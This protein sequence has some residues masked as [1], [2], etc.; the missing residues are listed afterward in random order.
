[1]IFGLGMIGRGNVFSLT[2]LMIDEEIARMVKRVVQGIT[3]SD[4]TLALDVIKAVGPRNDFLKEK[5]TRKFMAREQARVKL[6]DR[7][8]QEAWA[9]RADAPTM[10]ERARRLALKRFEEQREAA[11]LPEDLIDELEKIIYESSEAEKEM[12]DIKALLK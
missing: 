4:D 10:A 8:M 9:S 12:V 11:C 1:M 6:I 3:V 7:K 2:Q 5:H